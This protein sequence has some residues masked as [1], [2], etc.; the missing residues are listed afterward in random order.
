MADTL[1]SEK[2]FPVAVRQAINYLWRLC[3]PLREV[4]GVE[5]IRVD[6]TDANLVIF[7]NEEAQ[8]A[9]TDLVDFLDNGGVFPVYQELPGV[10]IYIADSNTVVT[11]TIL[12]ATQP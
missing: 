7:L 10:E 1:L 4:R 12:I 6:K 11:A 5:P 8:K 3:R 9:I 2:V